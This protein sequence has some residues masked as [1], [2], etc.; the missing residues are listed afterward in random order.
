M[1]RLL[2]GRFDC[3]VDA[4]GRLSL[5]SALRGQLAGAKA[6]AS[7]RLVVTNSIFK[8][9]KCLDVYSEEEWK[10][11]EKRIA[12]LPSL[13]AEV[14][15]YQRFYLSAGQPVEADGHNRLLVPQG[16]RKYADL[17]EDLV[18]IG[19]GSKL[20]IWSASKWL[21]LQEELA[22]QFDDIQAAVAALEDEA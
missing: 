9:R 12:A 4:K 8:G 15:A 17:E 3:K 14:Q 21:D 1:T 5:P 2:R 10:K 20:E 7:I 6:D 18:V 11:L 16:L 22:A 19:M 13:K